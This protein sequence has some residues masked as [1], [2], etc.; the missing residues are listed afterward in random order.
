MLVVMVFFSAVL[1]LF[2]VNIIHHLVTG[3]LAVRAKT[4]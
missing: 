4:S 1:G 3:Q 2:E